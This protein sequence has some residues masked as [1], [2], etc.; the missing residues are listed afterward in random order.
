MEGNNAQS[1]DQDHGTHTTDELVSE[2]TLIKETSKSKQ[3]IMNQVHVKDTKECSSRNEVESLSAD[4]INDKHNVISCGVG[5]DDYSL[6]DET[7]YDP[8]RKLSIRQRKHNNDMY[9]FLY[10][11]D[12]E[13]SNELKY[14]KCNEPLYV[15]D[16]IEFIPVNCV[17]GGLKQ[18]FNK[19][20]GSVMSI[21]TG[22]RDTIKVTSGRGVFTLD[23][24]QFI[25]RIGV[26]ENGQIRKQNGK[27][28]IVKD[29][30]LE[31]SM[32]RSS[33]GDREKSIV[34]KNVSTMI[35]K[36]DDKG[37]GLGEYGRA[38]IQ[39]PLQRGKHNEKTKTNTLPYSIQKFIKDNRSHHKNMSKSRFIKYVINEYD[40]DHV[41]T[42][43]K[44]KT[45]MEKNGIN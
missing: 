23:E 2:C 8:E 21:K 45:W 32:G 30:Q 14:M 3:N 33:H 42:S 24:T 5:D 11:S 29:Y 16:E 37:D 25:R 7:A 15:D 28:R 20:V 40:G 41:P 36:L 31:S 17:Q 18:N 34:E 19:T 12:E 44:I 10:D 35:D 38:F 9:M 4:K 13:T 26:F 6:D 39:T 22:K 27:V 1:Q 43:Y